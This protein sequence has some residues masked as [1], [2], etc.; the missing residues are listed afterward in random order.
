MLRRVSWRALSCGCW[1]M[2]TTNRDARV[3]RTELSAELLRYGG[4][5]PWPQVRDRLRSSGFGFPSLLFPSSGPLQTCR[6][7]TVTLFPMGPTCPYNSSLPSGI[8]SGVVPD[9]KIR[10]R[11]TPNANVMRAATKIRCDERPAN[12]KNPRPV[13]RAR[14]TEIACDAS[15]VR[16]WTAEVSSNHV[17]VLQA[18][19]GRLRCGSQVFA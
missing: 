8:L 2:R 7:L 4:R 5:W 16:C 14:G 6:G 19:R 10:C 17:T 13:A 11:F 12:A 15:S 1:Q 3:S 9:A 18:G